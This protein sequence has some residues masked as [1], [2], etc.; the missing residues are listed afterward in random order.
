[1]VKVE[2]KSEGVFLGANIYEKSVSFVRHIE[3]LLSLQWASAT[4]LCSSSPLALATA[5]SLA[6]D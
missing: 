2:E 3:G 4:L 1:M 6:R 5:L